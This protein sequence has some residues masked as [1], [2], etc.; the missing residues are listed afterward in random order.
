MVI[1]SVIYHN[2]TPGA[3]VVRELKD[4]ASR[5]GLGA[6][7]LT[8]EKVGD[9][10]DKVKN[11]FGP[12]GEF[13]GGISSAFK[14]P[15]ADLSGLDVVKFGSGALAGEIMR[16]AL[17][18]QAIRMAKQEGISRA[19]LMKLGHGPTKIERSM[20]SAREQKIQDQMLNISE[21][22]LLERALRFEQEF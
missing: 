6:N 11:F 15:D 1:G 7:F 20:M 16:G 17:N 21:E 4:I 8:S 12:I 13:V 2:L 9:W 10:G 22:Q 14:D 19:D 3:R 5:S 18:N